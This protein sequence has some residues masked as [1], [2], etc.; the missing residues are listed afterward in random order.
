MAPNIGIDELL[1][2]DP[3]THSIA[4]LPTMGNE[5]HPIIKSR[6]GATALAPDM[7]TPGYQSD[8]MTSGVP[9]L[10]RPQAQPSELPGLAQQSGRSVKQEGQAQFKLGMPHVTDQ[11]ETPGY[12]QQREE[13]NQYGKE[14]PWGSDISA[15]PGFLGKVGHALGVAG[16]IA[17]DAVAPGVMLNIPGTDLN[18]RL[19]SNQN[20]RGFDKA[21]ELQTQ[22]EGIE[23]RP[24]IAEATGELKGQL[25]AEKDQAAEKRLGETL[26]SR[27]KVAGE[28][29]ETKKEVAGEQIGSREKVAGEQIGSREKIAG[30]NIASREQI[31]QLADQTRMLISKDHEANANTRAAMANDPNKL[32]NTMKTMKQQAQ[33]TL[34]GID[35]ALTETAQVADMLGP[36]EGRWNDFIQGKIG[37]SDPRFAHYKDEIGMVSSA[38]TLAH[39]RG[40][41]SNELFDHFQQ[42]F[43]AGKQAPENMIQ[44]LDVAKEWLSDYANM[45]EPGSP[46]TPAAPNAPAAPSAG[47]FAAWKQSQ[48]K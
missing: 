12:F 14:H 25:Q 3:A 24:E 45:G 26:G 6:A 23:Q 4:G 20:E 27:E 21:Q 2:Y 44:A 47:G 9:S 19:Q 35:R 10:Q 32:T 13:V 31:A 30:A 36:G 11:P 28:G 15:H 39:A 1:G 46:G 34:P 29:N 18:R 48:S 7:A 43:D 38:V 40:R 22:K 8:A 42:M 5:Q 33:Q 16:N 17:G 37:V 41:M